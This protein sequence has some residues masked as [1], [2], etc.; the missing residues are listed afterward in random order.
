MA[1]LNP[2]QNYRQQQ[3]NTASRDKLVLMLFDGAIRF[4]NQ[5]KVALD[6]KQY[7]QVNT[8]LVK[9]QNIV[10]EFMITLDMDYEI[11]HSLYYLY[12]YC[13][14]RLIEAN[15]KKDQAIISEVTTFL[16]ELRLTFTEASVKARA[17]DLAS[18]GGVAIEG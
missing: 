18:T 11:S 4:C 13:Y 7:D 3:I 9:A 5:A 16:S 14:R 8:N 10:Q 12:D 6:N 2:Y 17:G 15:L 1:L